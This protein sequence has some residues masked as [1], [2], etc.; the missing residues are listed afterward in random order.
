MLALG[1]LTLVMTASD[2]T[3]TGPGFETGVRHI[4]WNAPKWTP[5]GSQIVFPYARNLFVVEADGSKIRRLTGKKNQLAVEY[6]ELNLSPDVSPDGSR[7]AY[8]S[9]K[10]RG[11]LATLFR[12]PPKFNVKTLQLKGWFKWKR[13]LARS[14]A[15]DINPVWSPD[16]T[17]IA[18]VSARLKERGYHIFT[19]EAGGSDVKNIAPSVGV[20]PGLTGTPVWSPDGTRLAFLGL[21]LEGGKGN[22]LHLY[23]VGADG[24]DLTRIGEAATRPAWSPDGLRIAFVGRVGEE[25]GVFTAGADGTAPT[26]LLD[27]LNDLRELPMNVSWSPDGSQLLMSGPSIS[28]GV[29]NADGSELEWLTPLPVRTGRASASWS[30][31]GSRIAVNGYPLWLRDEDLNVEG[32]VVLVTMDHDGGNIQVLARVGAS[33]LVAEGEWVEPESH[34]GMNTGRGS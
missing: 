2:C 29:I 11:V 9:F 12:G 31:D 7:V 34:S 32:T 5:D 16:G 14:D 33:D 17:R 22:L 25:E 18:F 10:D 20:P 23:T 27:Y 6:S 3:F 8:T 15:S 13:T 30:P 26:K 21:V 4:E 1:G 19:M 28:V 24:S